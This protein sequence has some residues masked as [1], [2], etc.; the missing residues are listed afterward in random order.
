MHQGMSTLPSDAALVAALGTRSIVLVGMMGAGKSSIGRRLAARL[1][2]PYVDA[3]HEIE[4][5][6]RMTIQDIFAAY[7]EASF[8]SGEMRVIARLLEAGPQVVATGG[9]AFIH[10]ETRSTI[11]RS[12][13]SIWLK[14]ATTG[15][16][17]RPAI[18]PRRS[19]S[20][21]PSAS[22]STPRPTRRSTPGKC[23]T[24]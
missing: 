13:V 14:A 2:I 16:C 21:S 1:G 3:D 9:G 8:R 15:R 6:A 18:L 24:R 5:A 23:R 22:R 19:Q 7:G 12:G 10:P 4:A 20:C 11:R 17:S